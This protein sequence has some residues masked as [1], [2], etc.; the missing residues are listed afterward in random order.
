MRWGRQA[1]PSWLRSASWRWTRCSRRRARRARRRTRR[2][3]RDEA[4]KAADE[5]LDEARKA[6]DERL[7][8]ARAD[9]DAARAAIHCMELA[10]VLFRLDVARGLVRTRS[11]LEAFYCDIFDARRPA[12]DKMPAT[13]SS[14]QQLL[15]DGTFL[16]ALVSYITVTAEENGAKAATVLQRARSLYGTLSAPMHASSEGGTPLEVFNESQLDRDAVIAF[17]AIARF[18]KRDP[19]RYSRGGTSYMLRMRARPS[20]QR[21]S[22]EDVRSG[23]ELSPVLVSSGVLRGSEEGGGGGGGEGEG[24]GEGEGGD[25]SSP[26]AP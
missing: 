26:R 11:L 8:K 20:D 10:G 18:A 19:A 24:E 12:P 13:P 5:R 25:L 15:L 7:E 1:G 21:A 22:E 16:P 6:A 23:P 2:A 17:A 14:K 9:T 4:R 3:R